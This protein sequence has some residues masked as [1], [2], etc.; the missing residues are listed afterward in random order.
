MVPA[1]RSVSVLLLLLVVATTFVV[2]GTVPSLAASPSVFRS[3]RWRLRDHRSAGTP[4]LDAWFGT[5]GD[6]PVVGDRNG[7]GRTGIGIVRGNEWRLRNQVSA[8]DPHLTSFLT[9]AL[10]TASPTRFRALATRHPLGNHTATHPELTTLSDTAVRN[11]FI[12]AHEPIRTVTCREPRPWFRFPYGAREARAISRANRQNY[13]SVRWTV[14][15]LGWMGTSGRQSVT[16][17]R[18]R[19]LA[20]L[21]P[22]AIVLMHLGTNPSDGSTPDADA[23][24]SIIASVKAPGSTFVTPFPTACDPRWGG[25]DGEGA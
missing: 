15:T 17:V 5:A 21:V 1:R 13:G 6:V 22:R 20:N 19:E 3:G 12:S 14:D 25:H 18:N 8:G 9:G 2:P 4:D 16:T 7:G 23:L 11:Q 10:T 24:A